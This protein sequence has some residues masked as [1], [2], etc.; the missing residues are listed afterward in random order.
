MRPECT[1]TSN[2]PLPLNAVP[3]MFCAMHASI[4]PASVP[5]RRERRRELMDA[6]SRKRRDRV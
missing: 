3:I 4:Y 1:C 6:I 5:N 2:D